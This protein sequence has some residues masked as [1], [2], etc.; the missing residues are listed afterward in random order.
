MCKK[1]NWAIQFADLSQET[2]YNTKSD[3]NK[4]F[5]FYK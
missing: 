5:V 1:W 3:A 4:R 2:S